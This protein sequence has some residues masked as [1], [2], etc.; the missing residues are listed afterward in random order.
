[1][2]GGASP[3]PTDRN[4]SS[5]AQGEKPLGIPPELA[6][7]A[8]DGRKGRPCGDYEPGTSAQQSQARKETRTSRNLGKTRP[9]WA[10]RN[11]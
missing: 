11:R 1:M 6:P 9:Q 3:S 4:K 7:R 2:A 10:G 8:P 5:H